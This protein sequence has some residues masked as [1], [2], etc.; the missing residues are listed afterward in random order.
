M[1]VAGGLT[2]AAGAAGAQVFNGGLPAGYTCTGTCATSGANG[3]VTLAPTGGTQFG[4]I[5]TENAPVQNPLGI[6]GTTNGS[7]LRS[8][9][10]V[11]TAGQN[12][13]FQFNYI[14][15]DGAGFSDY[16]YVRLLNTASPGSP[17]T[18]FTARTTTSGNTVPG[19]GLPGL[20]AGVTLTPP[21]TPIIAGGPV[22]AG[23]GSSSGDCY[24]TGCGYTGWIGMSYNILAAGS[25]QL[26]FGV[27]NVDDENYQSA[28]AFDFSTGV[29]NV[30]VVPGP[31]NPAVVPEPSTYAM[32]G[33]GLAGVAGIVRRRRAA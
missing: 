17:L 4:Y 25:Y 21:S 9:A 18:L 29:G 12:V 23:L 7:T 31:G 5:T 3:V 33:L 11:A 22:F 30:P 2:F 24:D 1:A 14:T 13:S 20:A 8:S 10:F 27:F 16:A 19:F 26:E 6:N 28:L 32:L 15:S